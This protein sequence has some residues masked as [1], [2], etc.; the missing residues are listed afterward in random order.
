MKTSK[1]VLTIFLGFIL[2]LVTYLCFYMLSLNHDRGTND[3][4]H[5][6]PFETPFKHLVVEDGWILNANI[7]EVPDLYSSMNGFNGDEDKVREILAKMTPNGMLLQE[8]YPGYD[9]EKVLSRIEIKNDTLFFRKQRI[10]SPFKRSIRL[11]LIG[12]N[13]VEISGSSSVTLTA[14]RDYAYD[15]VLNLGVFTIIIRDEAIARTDLLSFDELTVKARDFSTVTLLR[16]YGRVASD[17]KRITLSSDFQLSG[18]SVLTIYEREL[19]L[20]QYE[21]NDEA[22]L[23][24]PQKL[25]ETAYGKK[26]YKSFIESNE[27]ANISSSSN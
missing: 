8:Y 19:T 13:S 17:A 10:R 5:Y 15:T 25:I 23:I 7:G 22:A 24:Y 12:L 20:S 3:E 16:M 9:D 27:K 21:I 14:Q 18:N 2:T 6:V 26:Q 4:V 1:L 11:N